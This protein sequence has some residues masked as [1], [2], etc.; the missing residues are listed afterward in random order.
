ML[1]A[2]NVQGTGHWECGKLMREVWVGIFGSSLEAVWGRHCW[3]RSE[4]S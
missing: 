3:A 1:L 2:R 4:V